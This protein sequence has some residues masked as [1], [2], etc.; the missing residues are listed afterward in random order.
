V[1]LEVVIEIPKGSRNKYESD[2]ETGA[3]W[4]DRML[5]TATFYPTDYGFFPR[6]L[7]VDGDPLDALVLVDDPTFPG[8]HILTRPIGVFWMSD[9]KGP[10]A[11]VLT[12]P[13]TDPRWADTKDIEDLPSHLLDE[14]AH[15]FDVY[16]ALEP[17]KGTEI[18][19]WQ[20]R[21]EAEQAVRDAQ[22]RY[23]PEG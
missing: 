10:D 21:E 7:G 20:G 17:G 18:R 9:E 5:F 15:F 2:P 12:V 22:E 3:V 6:T 13:S 4:L 8:C 19:N 1:E 11:K 16:K 23:R 14:I